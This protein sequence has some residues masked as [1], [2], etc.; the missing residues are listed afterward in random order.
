MSG[1]MTPQSAQTVP[2]PPRASLR[3]EAAVAGTLFLVAAAVGMVYVGT[4]GQ[5]ADYL[6]PS[7]GP[8]AMFACG[9]G[10]VNPDDARCPSLHAFLHPEFHTNRPPAVDRFDCGDLPPDM[11][12]TGLTGF[13]RRT[14]HMLFL[15]G[16]FWYLL[17]VSWSALTPLFGLL[18]GMSAAAFYGLFRLGM[19]R[20]ISA[21]LTLMLIL[22]PLQ[23]HYLV[24]LRDYAKAP[25]L[26]LAVLC[27]LLVLIRPRTWRTL[28]L[29]A[30]GCGA[31]LGLATGFRA[32][33]IL[34]LPVFLL[35]VAAFL[36]GGF[37][38]RLYRITSFCI[39]F[40]LFFAA[41]AWPLLRDFQGYSERCH[42][43]LMGM[44]ELY[45]ERLGVRND[46]YQV[47]HRFLD[48]EPQA[49]L[50]AFGRHCGKA[51]PPLAYETP[52][53]EEVGDRYFSENILWTFP[54]DLCVRGYAATLRILDEL[55]AGVREG[56]PRGLTNRSLQPLFHLRGALSDL[57]FTHTRYALLLLLCLLAVRNLRLAL[58]A[59]FLILSFGF[60][61]S[62]QFATRHYFYLEFLALWTTGAFAMLAWT[63]LSMLWHRSRPSLGVSVPRAILRVMAF[64]LLL[65]SLML[66]LESFRWFQSH[67]LHRVLA[68]YQ[69]APTDPVAIERVPQPNESVRVTCPGIATAGP[70]DFACEF[71]AADLDT[72]RGD[73]AFVVAY[74]GDIP[75][76]ALTW[77]CRVPGAQGGGPTRVFFPV[78]SSRWD[79]AGSTWTT[80]LGLDFPAATA[81]RLV[82]L[83]RVRNSEQLPLL[84]TAVLPPDWE[85]QP[86]YQQFYR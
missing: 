16:L 13:Q 77:E 22:S 8:A 40:L 35:G 58:A 63:A 25:F 36:P 78:Y 51:G 9:K 11:P 74:E 15:A 66:P 17:G 83:F 43:F 86:L 84:L 46:T 31:A 70:V 3:R 18:Y 72:S 29:C 65:A 57:L 67:Q 61:S 52:E 48:T 81:D 6:Q 41:T 10:Y 55:H 75:D 76:R 79:P 34:L 33:S 71:L 30:A 19:N 50:N 26:L 56:M 5:T 69:T 82:A 80:F 60:L 12:V 42:P 28:L 21:F 73:V 53:Y 32:E 38:I 54:A 85:A 2:V 7:F 59:A 47:A 14:F 37:I 64:L 68:S 1:I 27:L 45:D 39:V 4:W 24:R 62:V 49:I 20:L 23:L 44:A